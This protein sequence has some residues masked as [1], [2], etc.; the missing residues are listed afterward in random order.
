MK[1]FINR[2]WWSEKLKQRLPGVRAQQDMAPTFRGSFKEDGRPKMAAVM[3]LLYPYREEGFLVF[4]KRNLYDGPHSGQVSFPG[5][6]WEEEDQDLQQTALR[7]TREELGIEADIRVLGALTPLHIPVSN[8]LVHPFLGW[9]EE[10][11]VFQP[12]ASE[13]QYLIE[14]ALSELTN[15]QIC[16]SE[17]IHHHGQWIHTPYYRVGKEKIWGATAM[18]LSEILRLAAR[19]Q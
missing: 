17:R 12:D 13:V 11:P 8:F 7:E 4:I 5:G 6:A 18:M 3:A 14:V 10:R 19:P 9:C 1:E 2:H 15:P 16:H